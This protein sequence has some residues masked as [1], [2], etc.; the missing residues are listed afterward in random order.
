MRTLRRT[1][2]A[3]LLTLLTSACSATNEPHASQGSA[4]PAMRFESAS[5]ATDGSAEDWLR[6]PFPSDER[7]HADGTIATEDMPIASSIVRPW[8]ELAGTL[9]NFGLQSAVFFAFTGALPTETLPPTPAASLASDAALQLVDLDSGTRYPVRWRYTEDPGTSNYLAAHTLAVAP[10]EGFVLAEGHRFAAFVLGPSGS[11][12]PALAKVL[13]AS[14]P[15]EAAERARWQVFAPLRAYAERSS[16]ERSRVVAATVFTTAVVSD[17][18]GQRAATVRASATAGD[19]LWK[20]A[21]SGAPLVA[22]ARFTYAVGKEVVYRLVGGEVT[23]ANLQRGEVPYESSGGDFIDLAR[24]APTRE[25]ANITLTVPAEAPPGATCLPV[26]LYAHGTGGTALSG[27]E[28]GTAPR[29]AARGM[30]TLS[31]DQ[32]MHGLRAHGKSFDVDTL[33]FNVGNPRAFRTTMR[34]GAL[35][36][37]Q[38]DAMRASLPPLPDGF[39][40]L[41]LCAGKAHVFA[42]SQGGLSAAM[43][44]GAG[45]EPERTLLSGAGGALHVTIAERKDP[46]DFAGLVRV[47]AKIGA[48]E[49]FDE[50]HP[51]MALLQ[52]L[53]DVSDPAVYARRWSAGG[54]LMQTAGL[55]DSNTPY[56]SATA[57][58]VASG[59][60]VFGETAW[61]SEP[62]D[63]AAPFAGTPRNA[64]RHFLE[65]GPGAQ[66]LDAS[67]W[68]VFERPEAIDASM[69]FLEAGIV[70]RNAAATAR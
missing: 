54:A 57:L 1:A 64:N 16:I 55:L 46:V 5:R 48:D 25:R 21:R 29:L 63:L 43:A 41:P 26:V 35:D 39:A 31:F 62:F 23:L 28:D 40:P 45:L 14:E 19:L 66:N 2:A 10:V 58:A 3:L 52:L 9:P 13:S 37:V 50:R 18:L 22:Q 53:G 49:P 15:L 38:I 33:T 59:Q 20:P 60:T 44:L 51:V 65:F 32:P 8:R 67:H 69:A 68:V 56:R 24:E 7:R 4:W 61:S 27:V 42:H 47:A 12:S 30:A 70:R 36:L 34:Q 11:T 6:L 17:D